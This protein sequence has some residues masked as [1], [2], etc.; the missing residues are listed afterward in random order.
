MHSVLSCSAESVRA[1][2]PAER[3]C[4]RVVPFRQ[5]PHDCVAGHLQLVRVRDEAIAL[6]L[7]WLTVQAQ[8]R[9]TSILFNLLSRD[10]V[11]IL[12]AR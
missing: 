12:E 11:V 7:R 6:Q 3:E 8:A 9:R 5:G 10:Q 1:A 4:R 2:R